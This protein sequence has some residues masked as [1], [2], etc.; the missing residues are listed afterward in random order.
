[1]LDRRRAADEL[2]ARR[3]ARENL[4]SYLWAVRPEYNPGEHHRE[5]CEAL[6]SLERREITRLIVEMPPR[7]GK[8]YHVNE[9]FPSWY[10]GRNPT[11]SAISASHGD[12]Q[13]RRS[14]RRVRKLIWSPKYQAIFPGT[15]LDRRSDASDEFM[16]HQ[17]GLY[18]AVGIHGGFM[19]SG[20]DLLV[21][22]DPFKSREQADSEIQRDKVWAT[23]D[24]LE[25]RIE[26]NGVCVCMHTRWHDDDLVG[27][28]VKERIETGK[29]HWHVIK[30]PL[31][32]NECA[33]WEKVEAGNGSDADIA[34]YNREQ[35]L[36]PERRSLKSARHIRRTRPRRTWVSLYQQNPS[37]EEG[38]F[39]KRHWFH[40]FPAT[41][42]PRDG[43]MPTDVRRY[44][45]ADF[46]VRKGGDTTE[47]YAVGIDSYNHW[48]VYDGWSGKETSDVW[49]FELVSMILK[50]RPDACA[51]EAGVIRRAV[52][53]FFNMMM[54]ERRASTLM[55][56][57]VRGSK[58][59][60]CAVPLQGIASMHRIHIAYGS[61]GDALIDQCA[62][63]PTSD[64]DHGVDALA[65]LALAMDDTPG[66]F[67][68]SDESLQD[69]GPKDSWKAAFD[70]DRERRNSGSW[71]T[72]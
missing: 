29:E 23:F 64:N 72:S 43:G 37:S 63:F 13:A 24:D 7:H 8:T 25:S 32:L 17:G 33:Q 26:P 65:N 3:R 15:R 40:R 12:R 1:M 52:E 59:E 57:P 31:I 2:L 10:L 58:K 45:C 53:P 16:T 9:G 61:W 47:F 54:D 21:I 56:W 49:C 6:Q 39:F 4:Q 14:G 66:A 34:A 5:L 27:R 68:V 71:K 62:A 69:R 41:A 50:E 35:A 55:L 46:G 67:A 20:A 38:D 11:H 30:Q 44:L 51:G 60:E 18:I 42:S 36:W 22:D 28:I 48:W 19:G 70:R